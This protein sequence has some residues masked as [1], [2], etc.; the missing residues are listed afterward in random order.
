MSEVDEEIAADGWAID[1]KHNLQFL[2]VLD[3]EHRV[4]SLLQVLEEV[5]AVTESVVLAG[6]V[7]PNVPS[8]P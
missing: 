6:A 5:S 3:R 2:F 7:F 8:N 4:L 1:R